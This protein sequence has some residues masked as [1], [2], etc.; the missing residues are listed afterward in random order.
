VRPEVTPQADRQFRTYD[1]VY[2]IPAE[3]TR[4]KDKITVKFQTPAESTITVVAIRL[5]N[6]QK[7]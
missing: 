6:A 3:M 4:G 7:N 1:Q 2:P 5:L